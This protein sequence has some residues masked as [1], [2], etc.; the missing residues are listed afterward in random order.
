VN[1]S[2]HSIG[3]KYF[4]LSH[5][6][7]TTLGPTRTAHGNQSTSALDTP[8][9][10][11]THY[12]HK[13]RA[14]HGTQGTQGHSFPSPTPLVS[15]SYIFSD[16]YH[17]IH[18]KYHY[19]L[20]EIHYKYHYKYHYKLKFTTNLGPASARK[21]HKSDKSLIGKHHKS[22]KSLIGKHHIEN[23]MTCGETCGVLHW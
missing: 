9:D 2:I 6:R 14:E 16:L 19:K 15:F 22:E 18:H 17:R 5:T 21:H 7:P 12:V 1:R 23:T 20:I 4:S 10:T 3:T 11:P 8:L 13:E